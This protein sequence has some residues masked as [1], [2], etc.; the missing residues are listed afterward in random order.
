MI[1]I[2]LHLFLFIFHKNSFFSLFHNF[3]FAL[4]GHCSLAD[5]AESCLRW[6]CWAWW[7]GW[8]GVAVG[9]TAAIMNFVWAGRATSFAC[10]TPSALQAALQSGTSAD[11]WL[12]VDTH[13]HTYSD[14][15]TI[16]DPTYLYTADLT[17]AL[18]KPPHTQTPPTPP[19]HFLCNLLK[20]HGIFVPADPVSGELSRLVTTS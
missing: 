7:V 2:L 14:T 19:T 9:C 3:L 1:G 16:C 12:T 13:I 10:L 11:G 4:W 17:P 18:S 20:C 5:W 6:A 8:G 15:D